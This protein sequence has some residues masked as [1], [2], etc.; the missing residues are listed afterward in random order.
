MAVASSIGMV[1]FANHAARLLSRINF[2]LFEHYA[3]RD[4]VLSRAAALRL[5]RPG[6]PALTPLTATAPAASPLGQFRGNR[7]PLCFNG[8]RVGSDRGLIR[9]VV[10]IQT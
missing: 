3:R 10:W 8:L 6:R 2:S 1:I 4:L 5:M 7:C 9:P